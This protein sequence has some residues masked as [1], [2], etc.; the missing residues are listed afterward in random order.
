MVL[1]EKLQSKIQHNII[2]GYRLA[3]CCILTV[4]T[5]G[6]NL[7]NAVNFFLSIQNAAKQFKNSG[8]LLKGL[9]SR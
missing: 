6:L 5:N 9:W 1:I 3:S 4:L 8:A 2:S 7:N